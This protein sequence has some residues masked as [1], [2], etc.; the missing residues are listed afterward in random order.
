MSTYY[1]HLK[2]IHSSAHDAALFVYQGSLGVNSS[3]S[4]RTLLCARSTIAQVPRER[5]AMID[6]I[7]SLP[8]ISAG[9]L[10][11][12]PM[13]PVHLPLDHDV[14]MEV[15]RHYAVNES[16]ETW[17]S[18]V[19]RVW[20]RLLVDHGCAAYHPTLQ[21]LLRCCTSTD[22][23]PSARATQCASRAS[24]SVREGSWPIARDIMQTPDVTSWS[25]VLYERMHSSSSFNI[26]HCGRYH[27]DRYGCEKV[28]LTNVWF[29]PILFMRLRML[30]VA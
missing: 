14:T 4:F 27:E 25:R 21:Q 5:D 29:A 16:Q 26:L 12:R 15:R 7:S 8:G 3:A 30:R 18:G 22:F 28:M 17:W 13:L 10:I 20:R 6:R 2:V 11:Y 19:I 23:R 24:K 1:G 9:V